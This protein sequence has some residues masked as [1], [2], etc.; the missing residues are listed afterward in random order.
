MKYLVVAALISLIGYFAWRYLRTS[1]RP[2]GARSASTIYALAYTS[3]DGKE[4]SMNAY[5]GKMILIVNVASECG[6]TPQYADLE[7]LYEAHKERLVVIGFPSNDFGSQEPGTDGE[8]AA[9]CRDNYGVSFPMSRKEAVTGGERCA[10]YRWL[11]DPSLNGWNSAGPKWNF[12]KYLVGRDG[13]LLA[14]FPSTTGPLSPDILSLL[15]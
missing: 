2:E 9:F 1:A 6:F 4:V 7:K 13:E 10:V 12:H 5:K 14:V 11:T 3:I 8:I 15:R